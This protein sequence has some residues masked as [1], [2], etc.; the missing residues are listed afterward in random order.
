MVLGLSIVGLCVVLFGLLRRSE[1][2]L[3]W[4]AIVV[5]VFLTGQPF[6]DEHASTGL[7]VVCVVVNV[8]ATA[9]SARRLLRQRSPRT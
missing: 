4:V 5:L 7:M 1:F 9:L 8:I 2:G 6:K 3:H